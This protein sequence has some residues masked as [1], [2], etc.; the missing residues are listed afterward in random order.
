MEANRLQYPKAPARHTGTY[1]VDHP[2]WHI[3]N[4]QRLSKW[5]LLD[6]LNQYAKDDIRVRGIMDHDIP[7]YAELNIIPL[8]PYIVFRV[9][10]GWVLIMEDRHVDM[11]EISFRLYGGTSLEVIQR[12]I[13]LTDEY[14]WS[15]G[16]IPVD[17]DT[18]ARIISEW[19]CGLSN[20]L[21]AHLKF[22]QPNNQRNQSS[23]QK[24]AT[25]DNKRTGSKGVSNGIS[26]G[27]WTVG[28]N[29]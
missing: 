11:S 27:S 26:S 4:D 2:L 29:Q 18:F 10:L 9:P 19:M 22:A 16:M 13:E 1:P 6:R 7:R 25:H 5:Q 8:G 28:S 3:L 23:T 17:R 14:E 12:E 15:R 21:E 20:S 24:G